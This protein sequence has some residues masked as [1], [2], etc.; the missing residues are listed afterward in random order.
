MSKK[1]EWGDGDLVVEYEGDDEA[2]GEPTGT[3]YER[4]LRALESQAGAVH[5]TTVKKEVFGG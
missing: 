3:V 2:V 5:E 1:Y 4:Y